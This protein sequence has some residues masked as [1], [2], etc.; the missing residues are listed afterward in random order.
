[1]SS[2]APLP[3]LCPDVEGRP[4]DLALP[5]VRLRRP[6]QGEDTDLDL[7]QHNDK[8]THINHSIPPPN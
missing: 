7:D 2:S 4:E 3:R 1:M 8:V 6:Q 5:H